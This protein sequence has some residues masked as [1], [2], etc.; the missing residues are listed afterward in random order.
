MRTAILMAALLAGTPAAAQTA[1]DEDFDPKSVRIEDAIAC[2][3]DVRTYNG[4][5]F[6]LAGTEDGAR[7]LGWAKIEG[8]DPLLSEYRLPAPVEAFGH[9][10]DHIAFSSSAVVAV[11][12]GVD[13]ETLA[14]G[15]AVPNMI[16]DRSK[17]RGERELTKRIERDDDLKMPFTYV[18]ALTIS[19]VDSHPGATLAGCSYRAQE[20][21]R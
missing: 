6:W 2:K 15:L 4:F 18:T 11:L 9:R 12:D 7:Q 21:D 17:F 10:T 3:L 20:G 14:A 1:A 16:P 19:T 13:A 8:P 5:A